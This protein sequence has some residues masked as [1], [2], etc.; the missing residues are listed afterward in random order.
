MTVAVMKSISGRS[1]ENGIQNISNRSVGQH[2]TTVYWE[3]WLST[4]PADLCLRVY[5]PKH[6]LSIGFDEQR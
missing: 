1:S 4:D 5:Q 3:A 6:P 2:F